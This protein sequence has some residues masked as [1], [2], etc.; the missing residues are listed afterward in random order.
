M[1]LEE[2]NKK[3]RKSLVIGLKFHPMPKTEGTDCVFNQA[4]SAKMAVAEEKL[5]QSGL[6]FA[7]HQHN[8]NLSNPLI[9]SLAITKILQVLSYSPLQKLRSQLGALVFQ[10]VSGFLSN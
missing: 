5:F 7:I 6:K 10:N 4:R 1:D 9:P 8:S 3:P 2:M